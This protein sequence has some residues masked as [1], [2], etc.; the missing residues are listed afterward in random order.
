VCDRRAR[1]DQRDRDRRDGQI[2][3]ARDNYMQKNTSMIAGPE[4]GRDRSERVGDRKP[5][6]ISQGQ[7]QE[8]QDAT[9]VILDQRS[10]HA[11]WS[12]GKKARSSDQD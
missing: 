9:A 10:P 1:R 2:L 4:A 6:A 5:P 12:R 11:N 7:G 8:V 3:N